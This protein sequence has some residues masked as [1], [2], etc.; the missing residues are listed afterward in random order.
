MKIVFTVLFIVSFSS[1]FA[2]FTNDYEVS[3]DSI[4]SW[5]TNSA[6]EYNGTYLFGFSEGES[7]LR[8]YSSDSIFVAQ[9]RS[10]IWNGKGWIDTFEVFTNV[11]IVDTQFYSD[12][13]IGEF[14]IYK[15]HGKT[16]KGLWIKNTW[17]YEFYYGGEIG[18]LWREDFKGKYPEASTKV[19][20][21]SYL[22]S[23]NSSELKIMRNEIYA[24]YSYKFIE[25]GKMDKYFS[26]Q[27]WYYPHYS[28]VDQFLTQIEHKNI[29]LIRKAEKTVAN[30]K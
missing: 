17:S 3:K 20:S 8:V 23:L 9:L 29:S 7:E 2:Q 24:R 13:A 6:E 28:N 4:S 14:V 18:K 22:G 30:T 1:L 27:S 15:L 25:G 12:Q 21:E 26:T 10:Y 11:R 19:L 16:E 5:N